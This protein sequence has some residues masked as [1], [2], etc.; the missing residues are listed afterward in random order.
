MIRFL[1]CFF[2]KENI[3][4]TLASTFVITVIIAII[5][6]AI[7]VVIITI[8]IYFHLFIYF[9]VYIRTYFENLSLLCFIYT[10]TSIHCCCYCLVI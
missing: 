9:C 10:C 8:Y 5:I 2:E 7:V 4:I 3:W 6:I 1:L